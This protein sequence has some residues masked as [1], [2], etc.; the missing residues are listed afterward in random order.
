[1]LVGHD[2]LRDGDQVKIEKPRT[3]PRGAPN[4]RPGPRQWRLTARAPASRRPPSGFFQLIVSRPVAVTMSVV[5]VCVF[6]AV[7][8]QKLPVTL[9]PEMTFPTLTV[10]TEYPG[11]APG[12]VEELVT[13]PMEDNV[14]VVSNLTG[15]RSVSRAGGSDVIL[16]FAWGTP[17]TFAV[18]EV[19]EKLD[20]LLTRLPRGVERP[21]VLRYDPTFD[22]ILRIGLFG[23]ADLFKLRAYAEDELKRKLETTPG[24]A[25]VKVK[26]GFEKELRVELSEEMLRQRKV[27]LATINERLAAENVN[28]ASGILRDGDASTWSARSTSSGRPRRS[29]T[30]VVAM[31]GG[32]PVRLNQLG[33]VTPTSKERDVITR[34]DGLESVEIEIYKEADANLVAVAQAVKTRLFGKPGGARTMADGENGGRGRRQRGGRSRR[35]RRRDGR[36]LAS[37]LPR[38][39]RLKVLSDQSAFI[40][41]SL[42]E[43]KSNAIEGAVLAVLVLYAFLRRYKP[44]LIIAISIPVSI[45]ATF[46]PLP[47][48]RVAQRDVARRAGDRRRHARRQLDRGARGDR[49]PPRARRG[50]V[51]GRGQRDARDGARGH[52]DHAHDRDRVPP[53][54]VRRGRRGP[55]LP[56]PGAGGRLQPHGVDGRRDGAR[57]DARGARAEDAVRA[58]AGSR[59]AVRRRHPDLPP[60]RVRAGWRLAG[61]SLALDG[62][63]LPRPA[64]VRAR[65]PSSRP[66]SSCCSSSSAGCV[67]L[68]PRSRF[69][70]W[71]FL[72]LFD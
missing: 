22:P 59:P 52:G 57:P 33:T 42:D 37:D 36:A 61:V 31:Q 24:V 62:P 10:R 64:P 30:L 3:A 2:R 70:A 4:R 66:S 16:E 56:R 29:A 67:V 55:D 47:A 15:Y 19:R 69:V 11:A 25:A 5:A 8:L 44:T 54:R 23:D 58:A 60:P 72:W 13:K 68:S 20:Q 63:A 40:E 51:L 49:A 21:L 48:R 34:I 43:V 9:L 53:D 50:R 45:L 14:A 7:S 26:G 32:Q 12:E 28:V 41:E 6:G 71:P 35:R 27:S 46:G 39:M 1:M 65:R 38:E 17:M 18:Q